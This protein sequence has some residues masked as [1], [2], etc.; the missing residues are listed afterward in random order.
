MGEWKTDAHGI[1]R[2]I[3]R[4]LSILPARPGFIDGHEMIV[5]G[6]RVADVHLLTDGRLE[7][8][9]LPPGPASRAT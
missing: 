5:D 9:E 6:R 8:I 1:L 3:E 7:I 4:V 2:R